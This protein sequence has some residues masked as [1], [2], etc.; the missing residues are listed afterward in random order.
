MSIRFALRALLPATFIPL[1]AFA[2]PPEACSVLKL[3]ELNQIAGGGITGTQ[4][5]KAGNPSECSFVDSRK[6][7]ILVVGLR[8]VQHAAE[9][10]LQYE[11]ET[12]EKIYRQKVK[13]VNTV[14]ESAFWLPANHQLGFRKG[15]VLVSVRFERPANQNEIDTAQVA[16]LVEAQIK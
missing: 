2:N 10:E 15:K 12:L 9:N 14:G 16:R 7:S 5:R 13:W 4:V 6:G 3:E 1:A 11:R 8:E